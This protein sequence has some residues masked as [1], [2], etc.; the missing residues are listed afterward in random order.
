MRKS[1]LFLAAMG[2]FIAANL[3]LAQGTTASLTGTVTSETKAL[4]G[5]TVTVSSP[6]LQGTR[7][8][9]TGA[10]GVYNFARLPPGITRSSS[11]S[12][13]FSRSPGR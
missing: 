3:C 9:V 5:V 11:S 1:N 2:L 13:V 7:T 10:N 12:R 6:E 4:P 8:K